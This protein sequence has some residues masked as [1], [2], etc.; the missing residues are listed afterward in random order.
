[1]IKYNVEIYRLQNVLQ[2]FVY[3]NGYIKHMRRNIRDIIFSKE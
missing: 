3:Q 2:H 1:M